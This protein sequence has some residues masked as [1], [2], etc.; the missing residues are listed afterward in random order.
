MHG[1]RGVLISKW[2][3]QLY[4]PV[5]KRIGNESLGPLVL[6]LSPSPLGRVLHGI[7]IMHCLLLC[8][9][10][11]IIVL[12]IMDFYGKPGA[13]VLHGLW[14]LPSFMVMDVFSY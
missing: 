3:I 7:L 4:L 6:S 14:L 8:L 13:L 11:L 1:P 9:F 12:F 10:C 5:Y 2:N